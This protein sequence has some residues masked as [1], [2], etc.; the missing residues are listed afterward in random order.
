MNHLS[1]ALKDATKLAEAHERAFANMV[2]CLQTVRDSNNPR[3][4]ADFVLAE[5]KQRGLL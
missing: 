5:L 3:E 2:E 1:E 4:A